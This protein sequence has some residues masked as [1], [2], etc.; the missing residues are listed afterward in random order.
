MR[1]LPIPLIADGSETGMYLVGGAVIFL[2][3][4]VFIAVFAR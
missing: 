1:G 4:I 3:S 2:A